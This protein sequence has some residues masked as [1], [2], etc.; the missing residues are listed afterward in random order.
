[1]NVKNQ[2]ER[3]IYYRFDTSEERERAKAHIERKEKNVYCKPFEKDSTVLIVEF[4]HPYEGSELIKR[5]KKLYQNILKTLN[6]KHS[7]F[8]LH[9]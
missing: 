8:I 5:A 6:I 1:M 4:D 9:A 2:D 3:I 7:D